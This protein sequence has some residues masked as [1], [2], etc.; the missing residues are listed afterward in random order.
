MPQRA[1]LAVDFDRTKA[2][3]NLG[4]EGCCC[5]L[6]YYPFEHGI[7]PL[8]KAMLLSVTPLWVGSG[9]NLF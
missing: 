2:I 3:L 1:Q 9:P 5:L 7:H 6:D 8:K 4:R